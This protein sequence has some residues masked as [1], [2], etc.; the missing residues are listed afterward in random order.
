[1]DNSRHYKG[2][3]LGSPQFF[4]S[5]NDVPGFLVKVVCPY[6]RINSHEVAYRTIPVVYM[7]FGSNEVANKFRDSTLV[8]FYG[9][10]QLTNITINN[11]KTQRTLVFTTSKITP[12]II[13]KK[14]KAA[15]KNYPIVPKTKRYNSDWFS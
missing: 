1:M 11:Q 7:G 8:E 6:T 13:R 4:T 10:E 15:T 2:Y 3:I 9:Y 5:K 14:A 12:V